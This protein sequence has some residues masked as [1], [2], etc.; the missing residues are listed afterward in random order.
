MDWDSNQESD[1]DWVVW[2]ARLDGRYQVEVTRHPENTS[3]AA[4][5]IYDHANDDTE[6]HTEQVTLAYGA[7]FGP[8]TGDVNAWMAL[9]VRVADQHRG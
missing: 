6:I 1:G 9:A 3:Q 7:V 5:T 4:L 2:W 8:D